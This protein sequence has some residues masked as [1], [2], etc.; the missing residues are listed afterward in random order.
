MDVIEACAVGCGEAEQLAGAARLRDMPRERT[1]V[2][3]LGPLLLSLLLLAPALSL[4]SL[5]LLLPPVLLALVALM[6]LL[7]LPLPLS[8]PLPLPLEL[9]RPS[10]L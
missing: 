8:L 9:A 7:A 3:A 1:R 10:R 2:D 6:P 5:A 4:P